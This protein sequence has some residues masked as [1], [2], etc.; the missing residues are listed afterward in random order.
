MKGFSVEIV[1][2][3]TRLDEITKEGKAA[4]EEKW[5]QGQISDI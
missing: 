4:R 1:F 3:A 5:D 2:K